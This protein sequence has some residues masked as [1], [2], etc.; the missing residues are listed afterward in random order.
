MKSFFHQTIR[1]TLSQT[2]AV[3]AI[4]ASVLGAMSINPAQALPEAQIT[5]K[6]TNVPVYVVG[7]EEG[8]LLIPPQEAQEGD[9]TQ[10]GLLVFMAKAEAESFVAEANEADPEFAESARAQLDFVYKNSPYYEATHRIY[11]VGRLNNIADLS[12]K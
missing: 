5:E 11:P 10:P 12:I 2:L 7:N 8:L 9:E 3:G 6:L 1:K 4:G